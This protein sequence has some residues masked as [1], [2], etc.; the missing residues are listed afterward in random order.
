MLNIKE[1]ILKNF[2]EPNS[3]WS[4][5]TSIV[6]TETLWKSMGTNNYLVGTEWGWVNDDN[7]FIFGWTIPLTLL[8]EQAA[9]TFSSKE[10]IVF[11]IGDISFSGSG[12]MRTLIQAGHGWPHSSTHSSPLKTMI[13][14]PGSVE[15]T[16]SYETQG[17]GQNLLIVDLLKSS[18]LKRSALHK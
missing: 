13:W 6:E 5:L 4:P 3:C 18:K 8:L 2:E 14:G 10:K 16:S 7:I 11:L 1:D 9:L 15:V 17:R 12:L